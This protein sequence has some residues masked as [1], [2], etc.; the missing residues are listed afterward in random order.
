M[1]LLL[2]VVRL[3]SL[4]PTHPQSHTMDWTAVYRLRVSD[5]GDITTPTTAAAS[6]VSEPPRLPAAED[7][8]GW[9]A[10]ARS[11][12]GPMGCSHE[13]SAEQRV[14]DMPLPAKLA[15][16]AAY[17]RAGNAYFK[18]GAWARA[19]E[20]YRRAL[21]Y[22]EYAFPDRPPPGADAA[23]RLAALQAELALVRVR[24]LSL[25]NCVAATLKPRDWAESVAGASQVLSLAREADE[26]IADSITAAAAGTDDDAVAQL[27][28]CGDAAAPFLTLCRAKSR[29]RRAVAYRH[30]GELA[31]A[32]DDLAAAAASFPA[33]ADIARERTLVA[34]ATRRAARQRA[35]LARSM[36]GGGGASSSGGGGGGGGVA[37]FSGDD[38]EEAGD[39]EDDDSS[40]VAASEAGGADSVLGDAESVLDADEARALR[41]DL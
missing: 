10:V 21:V 4:L 24:A 23:T 20:R 28:A 38:D 3:S 26:I 30:T 7:G 12:G 1:L 37:R 41:L 35:A 8:A 15:A 33:D 40:S 39:G 6:A 2:L 5:D 17:R 22:Y 29:Y 27:R 34:R 36:F 32:T 14:F 11:L 19:V 16:C 25:L 13:H 18:E 31:A 9:A